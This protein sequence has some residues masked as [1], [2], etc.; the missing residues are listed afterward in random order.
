MFDANL[1]MSAIYEEVND[2]KIV[3]CPAGEFHAQIVK[4]EPRHGTIGK[5]ERQGDDWAGLNIAYQIEDPAVEALLERTPVEVYELL[6]LD[7]TPTGGLDMGKGK[8]VRLGR[9]REACDL[10]KAGQPFQ[11]MMMV[12]KRL[13]VMVKHVPGYRD[14]STLVAEVTGVI[15]S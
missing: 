15:H 12:G 2:T 5:G 3:P 4:L 1:F 11:P 13:K 6:L 8:N 14:P 7:L 10:N 9:L